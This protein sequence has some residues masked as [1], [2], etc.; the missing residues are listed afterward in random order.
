VSSDTDGWHRT[1]ATSQRGLNTASSRGVTFRP[2]RITRQPPG[3]VSQR[4]LASPNAVHERPGVAPAA[5]VVMDRSWPVIIRESHNQSR[6]G[7]S[8]PRASA[9][10]TRHILRRPNWKPASG[11]RTLAVEML[12]MPRMRADELLVRGPGGRGA[13]TDIAMIDGGPSVYPI[14]NLIPAHHTQA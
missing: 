4:R 8:A 13:R 12:W 14:C 7:T 10:R 5:G 6:Q 11:S 2:D 9:S 3:E 1:R